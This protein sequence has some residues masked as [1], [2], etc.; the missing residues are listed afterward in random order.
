M[1]LGYN[2]YNK[3]LFSNFY[4]YIYIIYTYITYIYIIYIYIIYNKYI[5]LY[6][7]IFYFYFYNTIKRL[8]HKK[9]SSLS[10]RVIRLK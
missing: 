2:C 8:C 9:A 10:E 1:I 7:F 3:I 4:L 5:L 6:I